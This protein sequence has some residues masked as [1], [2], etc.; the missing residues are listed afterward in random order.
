MQGRSL[1]PLLTGGAYPH[2]EFASVYAEHGFGGLHYTPQDT[3]DPVQEG[4]LNPA[5][6]FDELNSWSQSG[7]MRM[8][9]KGDWKL[10]FDM[11]GK[12]Q[13]YHLVQDPGELQ[14]LYG[15]RNVAEIQQQLLA[16]LMAW[17][18]RIQDPLPLPRRRYVMKTD[19]RNYWSP[20]RQP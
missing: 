17:I 14:N 5:V 10:V 8:L 19:P 16:D 4:A 13:L 9:R 11:Q 2:E 15:R 20:Y 18:L 12:G 3:L 6:S 1:W 7:T